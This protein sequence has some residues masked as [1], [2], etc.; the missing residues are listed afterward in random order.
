MLPAATLL[1]TATID[2]T[3]LWTVS[4]ETAENEFVTVAPNLR[5]NLKG[6]RV[7][8]LIREVQTVV[9]PDLRH[10]RQWYRLLRPFDLV[11]V[12][13][14]YF[15]SLLINLLFR[16]LSTYIITVTCFDNYFTDLS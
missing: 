8:W 7:L 12:N 10:R 1:Q 3:V 9:A 15:V 5:P 14:I 16:F 13:K 11:T 2:V 4:R 6:T